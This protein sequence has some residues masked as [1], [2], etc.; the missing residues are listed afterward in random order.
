MHDGMLG[1]LISCLDKASQ[2][3]TLSKEDVAA[4]KTQHD[5]ARQVAQAKIKQQHG[6]DQECQDPE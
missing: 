5:A 2:D 1:E 3:T 6:A 4:A